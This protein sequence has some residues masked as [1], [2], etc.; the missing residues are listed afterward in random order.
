MAKSLSAAAVNLLRLFS[1]LLASRKNLNKSVEVLTQMFR[2]RDNEQLTTNS[3]LV[4]CV[5]ED[6]ANYPV[7][8]QFL[9]R[10]D[11]YPSNIYKV[12]SISQ[13]YVRWLAASYNQFVTV[14]YAGVAYEELLAHGPV[15]A[16]S[17][18][19]IFLQAAV[20]FCLLQ[21]S[22]GSVRLF[23]GIAGELLQDLWE[24]EKGID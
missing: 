2:A 21:G 17:E 16:L 6:L 1:M 8:V 4:L 24:I 19:E 5:Q 15:D 10:L 20:R 13:Q 14:K 11:A 23:R 18:M 3:L 9:E 12:K 22:T 7:L